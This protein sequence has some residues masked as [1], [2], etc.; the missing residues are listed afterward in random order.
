MVEVTPMVRSY[1]MLVLLAMLH[2]ESISGEIT[3]G[4]M[5]QNIRRIANRSAVLRDDLGQEH[6]ESDLRLQRHLERN[7]IEAWTNTGSVRRGGATGTEKS[8]FEYREGI[9]RWVG[10]YLGIHR[11]RFA[12]LLREL[13]DWRLAEY[14]DRGRD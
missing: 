7:P 14:L 5:V 4:Q 13:V 9:F 3:I 2:S 10:G 11:E 1:K 8:Y 6:M 12:E